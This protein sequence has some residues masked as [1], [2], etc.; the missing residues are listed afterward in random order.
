[1]ALLLTK[2]QV[3]PKNGVQYFG[4]QVRNLPERRKRFQDGGVGISEN[5]KDQFQL[6]DPEGTR[7]VLTESG[8]LRYS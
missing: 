3:W 6:D 5:A 8:W 7:M 2:S 4:I 1:V